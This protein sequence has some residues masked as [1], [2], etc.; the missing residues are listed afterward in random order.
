MPGDPLRDDDARRI[1][2]LG[3]GGPLPSYRSAP[4]AGGRYVLAGWWR[5]VGAALI[6]ALIITAVAVVIMVPL[7]IGVFRASS[8]TDLIALGAASLLALLVLLVVAFLYAPLMMW[9]TDGRTVGRMA[10]GI[11]VVRTNGE[12]MSFA[13]AAAR[14][15]LIKGILIG[16]ISQTTFGVVVLL[17]ILWPLW[18][19]ENRALHDF[20][21]STRT[22]ID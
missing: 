8:G 12:P 4:A 15:V 7:G 13:L 9:R 10:T 19:E 1:A 18:D 6:D 14:E 3:A 20:P 5:R 17:D 2:P 21:V 22:V 16:V 11:R